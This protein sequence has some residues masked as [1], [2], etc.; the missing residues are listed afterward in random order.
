MNLNIIKANKDNQKERYK[1]FK[2]RKFR[3]IRRFCRSKMMEISN[4]KKLKNDELLTLRESQ[5]KEL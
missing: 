4:L 3:H 5:K 2:C 1:Y